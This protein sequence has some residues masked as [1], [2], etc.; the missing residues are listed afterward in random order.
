MVINYRA[1]LLLILKRTCTLLCLILSYSKYVEWHASWFFVLV[2]FQFVYPIQLTS[3]LISIC[4]FMVIVKCS[5][6]IPSVVI[7]NLV[8]FIFIKVINLL[9]VTIDQKLPLL[10]KTKQSKTKLRRT[11]CLCLSYLTFVH[12]LPLFVILTRPSGFH[13]YM[14]LIFLPFL[15]IIFVFLYRKIYFLQT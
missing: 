3:Q 5:L 2:W 13:T 12:H 10:K 4:S 7:L 11:I 1:H 8:V 9:F 6:I 14:L 15:F